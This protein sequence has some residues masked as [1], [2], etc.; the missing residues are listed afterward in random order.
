VPRLLAFA[1]A[2]SLLAWIAEA[3]SFYL[4]LQWMGADVGPML[5]MSFYAI[6]MLAGALSFM[7]GGIGGAEATMIALLS[8]VGVG[9]TEAVAATVVIRLT[10]L[11][12]AVGLGAFCLVRLPRTAA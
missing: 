3:W 12:F 4:V 9:S 11:W 1:S 10:T 2:L 6:A 8:L 7:P 5:A